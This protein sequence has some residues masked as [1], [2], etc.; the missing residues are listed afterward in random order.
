MVE[1]NYI[2]TD[3]TGTQAIGNNGSGVFLGVGATNNTIG[4]TT[5]AARNIISGNGTGVSMGLNGNTGPLPTGNAILGNSIY[6]NGG[7]GIDLASGANNNQ[8]APVLTAAYAASG[9]TIV[10]RHDHQ[11]AQRHGPGGVL[12]QRGRRPRRADPARQPSVTTDA[13][14]HGSFTAFLSARCPRARAS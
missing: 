12:R 5:P 10:T 8:A 11:H 2:G 4:G 9:A 6:Y 13:A 14:G 7:L 1:G 3:I